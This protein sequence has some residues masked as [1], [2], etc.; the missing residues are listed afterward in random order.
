MYVGQ[1]I[2]PQTRHYEHIYASKHRKLSKVCELAIAKYGEPKMEIIDTIEVEDHER[3]LLFKLLN[4]AEKK[5]IKH[6]DST[7]KSGKGYNI[8][9]GGKGILQKNLFL[10]RLGGK[11]MKRIGESLSKNVQWILFERIG[12]SI[13]VAAVFLFSYQIVILI[14]Q[15]DSNFLK[16]IWQ[17]ARIIVS[18][19]RKFRF[20]AQIPQIK[21]S[22]EKAIVTNNILCWHY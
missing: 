3:L 1:T 11:Y 17:I 14:L 15:K 7:T 21:K 10:T 4:E 20:Y 22:D 18:L 8:L 2:H 16:N 5:W 13:K 6:Y 19:S 12:L 9:G